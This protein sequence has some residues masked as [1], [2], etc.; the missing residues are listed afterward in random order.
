MSIS[1]N[2]FG[3]ALGTM[4]ITGAQT[5]W[6]AAPAAAPSS[7][8]ATEEVLF[9]IHD[10]SPVKNR[11]G[12]V[13][14][15]DYHA[16]FYNRSPY[17]INEASLGFEWKDKSL[18]NVI[19]DEKNDDAQKKNRNMNR[20]YS[21]TERRT[22]KNVTTD[23]ELSGLKPYRQTTISGRV[24]SDRCFLLLQE[25]EFSVRSC[26]AKGGA[27]ESRNSARRAGRDNPCSRMFK[28]VSPEDAQYYLNFKEITIDEE[29]SREEAQKKEKREQT[30]DVYSKTVDTLN[31]ASSIIGGIK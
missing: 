19:N 12:E 4:L 3:L 7:E 13:I 22:S 17:E 27:A 6:A 20:A 2:V 11:E 8:D 23:I 31:S 29:K 15:C 28:F 1:K 9:K 30:N 5:V 14:A 18:E 21:E 26:S 10:I 24:N 16:T 25:V